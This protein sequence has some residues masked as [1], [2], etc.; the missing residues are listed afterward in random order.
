[1]FLFCSS[2]NKYTIRKCT[3]MQKGSQ[4]PMIA[5]NMAP[6]ELDCDVDNAIYRQTY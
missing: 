6:V 4:R 3:E 1:M 5:L 2:K